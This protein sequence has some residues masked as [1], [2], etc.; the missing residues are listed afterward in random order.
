MGLYFTCML[1]TVTSPLIQLKSY[2]LSPRRLGN[3]NTRP[4][5]KL[6]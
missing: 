1:L 3:C 2:C 6:M 5:C 4:L